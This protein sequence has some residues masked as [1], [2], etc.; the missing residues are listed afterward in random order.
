M[1]LYPPLKVMKIKVKINEWDLIEP[2][3]F[4]IS[5]KDINK[6]ERQCINGRK[7]LQLMWL[8]RY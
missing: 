2:K 4:C 7:Y 1:F 3:S 5:K 8:I 6:T